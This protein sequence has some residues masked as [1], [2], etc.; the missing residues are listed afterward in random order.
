LIAFP[1][2]SEFPTSFRLI[3]ALSAM[4]QFLKDEGAV[5][6]PE[7]EKK[8]EKVIRELKKVMRL[9]AWGFGSKKASCGCAVR[10]T[11]VPRFLICCVLALL[12]DSD[13]L[14]RRGGL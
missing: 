2:H 7:D 4:A 11:P 10:R 12:S 3:R 1:S 6:S 14:G 13:A 8:R 5:P 9:G